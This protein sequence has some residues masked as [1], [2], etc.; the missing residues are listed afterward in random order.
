MKN[1]I[2]TGFMASGKTTIGIELA[3]MAGCA[4]VD[5]DSMIEKNEKRSIN[6][7]FETDGEEYFRDAET[8]TA[9]KISKM[10]GAVVSTGGG[11]ILRA[12]NIEHLRKNGIVFFLDT[13]FEIIAKRLRVS[14]STRPLANGQ[15]INSLRKRYEDRLPFYN[16]CDYRIHISESDSP[17]MCAKKY[18][19]YTEAQNNVSS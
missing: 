7:I 6:K 18:L 12:E 15:D 5:T 4:F 19:P 10:N 1:I 2:L 3:K 17:F 9:K 8:E 16:N 11:M 14:D 13:D